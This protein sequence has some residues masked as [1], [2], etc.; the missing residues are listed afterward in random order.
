MRWE[1]CLTFRGW[2]AL[3]CRTLGVVQAR[4]E[5]GEGRGLALGQPAPGMLSPG[6]DTVLVPEA[7]D[8]GQIQCKHTVINEGF[9]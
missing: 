7:A 9:F 4:L 2:G 1:A 3:C 6:T 8:K 5:R